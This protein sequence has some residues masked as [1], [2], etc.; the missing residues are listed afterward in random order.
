MP[1]TAAVYQ[2]AGSNF[3]QQR[4]NVKA[5]EKWRTGEGGVVSEVKFL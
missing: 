2:A 4:P 5:Y 3:A 1:K